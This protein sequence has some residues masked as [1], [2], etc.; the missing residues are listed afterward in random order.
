MTENEEMSPGMPP[1]EY[2]K[3]LESIDPQEY[4][5][6][7]LG[8]YPVVTLNTSRVLRVPEKDFQDGKYDTKGGEHV[9]TVEGKIVGLGVE[10]V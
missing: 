6:E 10:K 5:R 2:V 7:I 9:E 1:E 3:M 8:E 4:L